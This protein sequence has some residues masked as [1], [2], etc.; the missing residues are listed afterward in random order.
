MRKVYIQ[1][2]GNRIFSES[3]YSAALGFA[4][5]GYHVVECEA[6]PNLF[7]AL[8]NEPESMFVG[9]I[10]TMQKAF[11]AIAVTPPQIDNPHIHLPEY[12]GREVLEATWYDVEQMVEANQL[13]IFVKPLDEQKLFTGYVVNNKSDLAYAK[14]DVKHDTKILI[15]ETVNFISEYRCFVLNGEMVG[16]KNYKGDFRVTPNFSIME[17]AIKDY[18]EQPVAYSIDFGVTD[19][20]ATLLIEMNDAYGLGSYGLDK[21]IYCR[22]LEARWDEIIKNSID[23]RN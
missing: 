20:G 9:G 23:A 7:V 6:D 19:E 16:C 4:H 18:K 21:N 10:K 5:K 14:Y 11:R 17:S 12:L 8:C 2:Q 22:L 15:S 13:P 1:K 3:C